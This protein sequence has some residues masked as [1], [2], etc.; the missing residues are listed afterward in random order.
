MAHRISVIVAAD[1][2]TSPLGL[3]TSLDTQTLST[4][5]FELILLDRGLG[6]TER[7]T[8]RRM[9]SRRPNI[10]IIDEDE[11]WTTDAGEYL[12]G[13]QPDQKLF[14]DALSRLGGFAREHSLDVVAGRPVQPHQALGAPFLTD[15][16]RLADD[17]VGMALSSTVV[18]ARRELVEPAARG[19]AAVRIH[20]DGAQV[21]VLASYPASDDPV[22]SLSGGEELV[23]CDPPRLDWE[24]G[25]LLVSL[26]G[27]VPET[28][29][30]DTVAVVARRIGDHLSYVLPVG[31]ASIQFPN[32]VAG[33]GSW[34][35]VARLDP[36]TAAAGQ[37]LPP[38][39][40]ELDVVLSGPLAEGGGASKPSPVPAV[41]GVTALV[42][43]TV[44]AVGTSKAGA[45]QID[46]GPSRLPVMRDLDPEHAAVTE[47][48]RGS[49]LRIRL[50]TMYVHESR[51][52]AG[53][54]GPRPV[55]TAGPD[56]GDRRRGLARS[57]RERPGRRYSVVREVRTIGAAAARGLLVHRRDR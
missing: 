27:S 32:G 19:V 13:V 24:G 48:A 46:I 55:T 3:V 14:P 50:P 29:A 31:V 5:D 23:R 52:A 18:L 15:Q 33:S 38:G 20:A 49:E 7:E 17:Q 2:K 26:G 37:P 51:F 1:G 36:L 28:V 22:L 54:A 9:A 16:P 56:R 45:L 44:L 53:A 4:D 30:P 34:R 12:L 6:D 42:Q 57:I 39:A 8:L 25:E 43:N 35:V 40:W 47:S 21:G 11:D 10:R 41:P